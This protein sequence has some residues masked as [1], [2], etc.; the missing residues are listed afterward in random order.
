MTL[1]GP[2]VK[3]MV[4]RTGLMC[5]VRTEHT[6][7]DIT[8]S[9]RPTSLPDA[10]KLALLPPKQERMM[11]RPCLPPS[12]LYSM[13]GL[14]GMPTT[15]PALP[16]VAIHVSC[17]FGWLMPALSLNSCLLGSYV[18]VHDQPLGGACVACA[19]I[20]NPDPACILRDS[21]GAAISARGSHP[22]QYDVSQTCDIAAPAEAKEGHTPSNTVL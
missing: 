1:S 2:H 16:A 20:H 6:E 9:K 13:E 10:M 18:Y 19:P 22:Q 7:L 8:S 3:S 4:H 15:S 14:V 12:T 21:C 5:K 17:C 11:K